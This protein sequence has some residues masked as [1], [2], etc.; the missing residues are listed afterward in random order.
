MPMQDE[1][2]DELFWQALKLLAE[3]GHF[4]DA[5]TLARAKIA[6]GGSIPASV[7]LDWVDGLAAIALSR[8]AGT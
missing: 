2:Y 7:K 1:V 5:I 8:F 6:D 4:S 3:S